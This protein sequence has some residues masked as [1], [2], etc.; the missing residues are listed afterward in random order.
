MEQ[1]LGL[2]GKKRG[3]PSKAIYDIF[4]EPPCPSRRAFKR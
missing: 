1:Y 3:H 2:P 4:F